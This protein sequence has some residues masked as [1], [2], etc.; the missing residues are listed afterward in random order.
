MSGWSSFSEEQNFE[1]I[2]RRDA[3]RAIDDLLSQD[4]TRS[5]SGFGADCNAEYG[6]IFLTA[7]WN[8]EP[9]IGKLQED[10]GWIAEWNG[11]FFSDTVFENSKEL[12]R[13]RL[14]VE[15]HLEEKYGELVDESASDNDKF[16]AY[17]DEFCSGFMDTVVRILYLLRQKTP[18]LQNTVFLVTDHDEMNSETTA[19]LK[20]VTG[21]DPFS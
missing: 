2:F 19:R 17:S 3:K 1:E 7:L 4:L 6:D 12:S 20:R 8:E 13:I 5:Y 21:S 15:D 9:D 10:I 18:A 16:V 14:A 11:A